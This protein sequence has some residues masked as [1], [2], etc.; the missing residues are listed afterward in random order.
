MLTGR[1]KLVLFFITISLIFTSKIFAFQNPTFKDKQA[2]FYYTDRPRHYS[3]RADSVKIHIIN[4]ATNFEKTLDLTKMSPELWKIVIPMDYLFREQGITRY[5]YYY[6]FIIDGKK[7]LDPTNKIRSIPYR[8]GPNGRVCFFRV[9]HRKRKKQIITKNPE[10]LSTGLIFYYT[11]DIG[12]KTKVKL[13][14]SDQKGWNR[15]YTLKRNPEGILY[16]FIKKQDLPDETINNRYVYKF[17]VK[18]KYELDP[19]NPNQH[20]SIKG[21]TF[22]LLDLRDKKGR[23]YEIPQNP[24]VK[25]QGLYFYCHAPDAKTVG[26]LTNLNGWEH[27]LP[28]AKSKNPKYEGAWVI[29][30]SKK[31]RDLPLD[32][33]TYKYKFIIDGVITHD[34]NNPNSIDDGAGGKISVFTL[35]KPIN[36]YG[37]NPIHIKDN[38]YRFFF[39]SRQAK[40]VFLLGSFNNWNPFNMKMKRINKDLFIIDVELHPGVYYYLFS[41]DNKWKSD[42]RNTNVAYNQVKRRVSVVVIKPR[43]RVVK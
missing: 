25:M 29:L 23:E 1:K 40:R 42:P 22:N 33:G 10:V 11:K 3:E 12:K 37:R 2:I 14:I 39:M 35:K 15:V 27:V 13:L 31:N 8:R 4:E 7:I 26:L 28:M 18:G 24:V 5:T 16:A 36:Y 34:K 6:Y 41:V 17:I 43:K 9:E 32:A 21:G 19:L 20:Q 30:L 38:I